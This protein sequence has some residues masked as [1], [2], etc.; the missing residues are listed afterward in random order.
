MEQLFTLKLFVSLLLVVVYFL[1]LFFLLPSLLDFLSPF[2]GSNSSACSQDSSI[3][4]FSRQME[5]CRL[6]P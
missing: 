4:C 1:L 6:Q 5:T 2:G 3:C